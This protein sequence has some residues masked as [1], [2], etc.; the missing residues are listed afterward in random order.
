M[1]AINSERKCLLCQGNNLQYGRIGGASRHTFIP[2]N[3]M[4]LVGYDVLAYV[5]LDCGTLGYYLG[6]IDIHDIR[7]FNKKKKK[8]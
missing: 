7:E 4:M 6:N 8:I 1:D 5:C 3:K 2:Q